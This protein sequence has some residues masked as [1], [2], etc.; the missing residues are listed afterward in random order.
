MQAINL[1]DRRFWQRPSER[2]VLWRRTVRVPNVWTHPVWTAASTRTAWTFLGFAR[3]PAVRSLTDPSGVT[4]V[5]WSDLRFS[6][7]RMALAPPQNDPF[8]VIVQVGPDGQV[9][10]EHLGP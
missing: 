6:G 8:S 3:L 2:E 10:D 7:A 1:L 5:R 4:T 9:I